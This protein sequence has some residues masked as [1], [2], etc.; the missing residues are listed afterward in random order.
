[1]TDELALPVWFDEIGPVAA[2]GLSAWDENWQADVFAVEGRWQTALS[3]LRD[4]DVIFG[5]LDSY[6]ERDQ[7]EAFCRRYLI[8]YIDIGMDVHRTDSGYAVQ[9]QVI[10]S[11]PGDLCLRCFNFLRQSL[12][13]REAQEYGGAGGRPQAG[14]SGSR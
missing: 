10:L 1:M 7:L 9:G 11:M 12:L 6:T 8:P 2:A 4:C 3:R 14:N 5:C 13:D